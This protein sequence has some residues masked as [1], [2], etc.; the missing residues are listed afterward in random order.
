MNK[1]IKLQDHRLKLLKA[2]ECAP[3]DLQEYKES[4]AL[5]GAMKELTDSLKVIQEYLKT[6]NLGDRK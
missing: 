1:V 6:Y 3:V 2:Q 4:V 5:S